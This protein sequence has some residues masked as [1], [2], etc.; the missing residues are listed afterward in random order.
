MALVGKLSKQTGSTPKE[1]EQQF[2]RTALPSS[3]LQRFILPSEVAALV[4]FVCSPAASAV[5]GAA[6]RVDSGVV[7]SIL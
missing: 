3:L 2:F 4:T 7:R 1:F 6:L 5:N